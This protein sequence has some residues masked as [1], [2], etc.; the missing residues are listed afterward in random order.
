MQGLKI[1]KTVINEESPL[2]SPVEEE[3]LDYDSIQV[4]AADIIMNPFIYTLDNND[5]H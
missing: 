5:E 4:T 3:Q 1:V 2:P